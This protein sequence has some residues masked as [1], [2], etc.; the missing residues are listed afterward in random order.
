VKDSNFSGWA[1]EQSS[2]FPGSYENI[3][4]FSMLYYAQLLFLS[5]LVCLFFTPNITL[6]SGSYNIKQSPLIAFSIQ[7]QVK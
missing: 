4:K 5:F 1:R 6:A 3:S 7:T 2:G